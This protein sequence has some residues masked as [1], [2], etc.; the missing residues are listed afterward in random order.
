MA[1]ESA[2]RGEGGA[3]GFL[4]LFWLAPAKW[5]MEEIA[6]NAVLVVCVGGVGGGGVDEAEW[7]WWW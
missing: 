4:S 2:S 5:R 7:W 6:A 3:P 1:D